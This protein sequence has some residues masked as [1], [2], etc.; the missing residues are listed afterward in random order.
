MI[1]WFGEKLCDA[2]FV[3]N[4]KHRTDRLENCFVELSDAGIEGVERFD[5]VNLN[6]TEYPRFGCTQSHIDIA[7]KQIQ[8]NWEYVLYLEDDIESDFYYSEKIKKE[9]VNKELVSRRIIKEFIQYKPDILWLGV[10]PESHTEPFT[11]VLVKS[12]KTLMSHAYIGS[13]KYAK[14]LVDNLKY[15]DDNHCCKRYAIDFFM[16]QIVQKDDWQL[17]RYNDGD[18]IKNNDLI[19]LIAMPMIFTQGPSHSNLTEIWVDYRVWVRGSID[20]YINLEKLKI[21]TLLHE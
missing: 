12:K 1:T 3:I 4:L 20:Y 17:D 6:D 19:S 9:T 7:K 13:L 16:S 18:I 2:G 14:F 5:A 11:D 21:K 8:N 10:R 15:T